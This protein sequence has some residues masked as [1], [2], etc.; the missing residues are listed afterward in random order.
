MKT[1]AHNTPNKCFHCGKEGHLSYHCPKKQNQQTPQKQNSHQKSAPNTG[2]V[3]H[4]SCETTQQKPEVMLGTFEVN[5][6]PASILFDS[7]ASHTFISQAFVRIHSLPLCAMKNPILVNSPRGSM[8]AAYSCLPLTLTLRG[9]E[10]KIC[11]VVLGASGID[12]IL[13]MD[14]IKQQDAS[15]QCKGKAVA[16]T[17]PKGDRIYVEVAVQHQPT[18]TVNQLDNSVNQED[19]VVDEFPDVFPDDF[20]GMPP[21]RDIEFLLTYYLAL[22]L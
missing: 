15:I 22:H 8:Q 4:M 14:W 17:T 7:G 13:G 10:F 21:D 16:L 6:I 9:V 11:P 19:L 5:S 20:P 18:A 12:V 3:N 1:S 2:R